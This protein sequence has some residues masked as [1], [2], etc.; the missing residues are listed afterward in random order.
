[1][2]IDIRQIRD[3]FDTCGYTLMEKGRPQSKSNW[4]V[5][6]VYELE[7][8][9]KKV[10][11][12]FTIDPTDGYLSSMNPSRNKKKLPTALDMVHMIIVSKETGEST[13]YELD[14]RNSSQE[15]INRLERLLTF[16]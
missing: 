6:S 1:M 8:E 14:M 2:K 11:V 12:S 3:I 4:N 15:D 13:E 7:S 9:F 16:L 10:R 5:D